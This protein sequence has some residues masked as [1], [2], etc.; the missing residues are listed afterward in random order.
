MTYRE[1]QNRISALLVDDRMNHWIPTWINEARRRI[2]LE[3]KFSFL[4]F[5]N[6]VNLSALTTLPVCAFDFD[7]PGVSD[8]PPE[9][10]GFHHSIIYDDA[11]PTTLDRK[12]SRIDTHLFNREYAEVA[13]GEPRFYKVEGKNFTLNLDP[14]VTT[15]KFYINYYAFPTALSGDS[16][17]EYIDQHYAEAVIANVCFKGAR[18]MRDASMIAMW[19]QE[20]ARWIQIMRAQETGQSLSDVPLRTLYAATP[21]AMVGEQQT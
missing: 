4:L 2:C 1:Y 3:A 9:F 13:S 7:D 18:M 6:E 14:T 10:C 19:D 20:Y 15:Q 17:E 21:L 8:T 16:D 11:N 12:L 5:K